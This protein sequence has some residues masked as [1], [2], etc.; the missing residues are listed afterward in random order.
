VLVGGLVLFLA[1]S[2]LIVGIDMGT[3]GTDEVVLFGVANEFGDGR[4]LVDGLFCKFNKLPHLLCAIGAG[5]VLDCFHA[6]CNRVHDLICMGDGWFRDMFVTEVD[7]VHDPFTF[8][9]F[10]VTSVRAIMFGGS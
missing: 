5:D 9:C 7:S 8:G 10:D 3:L 4:V 6:V 1:P 2:E